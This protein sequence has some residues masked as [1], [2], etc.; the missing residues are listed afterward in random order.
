MN[1]DALSIIIIGLIA[2]GRLGYVFFYNPEY[3]F[4]NPSEII[5]IWNGGMSF[6][7]ALIGLVFH[8]IIF[9]Y[10]KKQDITELA[11]LLAFSSPVGIFFGRIANFINGEPVSYTHLTLPT[12]REV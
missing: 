9:S 2:G 10:K 11:N 8:M 1:L 7:G 6:H 5:M 4:N 3:F 12:N